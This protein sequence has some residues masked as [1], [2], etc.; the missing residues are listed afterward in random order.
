VTNQAGI[1]HGNYDEAALD[2]FHRHMDERLAEAGAHIDEYA[3]C[4]FHPEA[5]LE[6]YRRESTHRKPGPGMILDLLSDWP[7]DRSRSFLV[8]DKDSDL[9]AAAAASIGAYRYAGG[10]LHMLVAEA[11]KARSGGV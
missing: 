2:R 3:Y 8:G 1:A 6:A 9:E 10:D 7:V 11:L 5:K 4:P